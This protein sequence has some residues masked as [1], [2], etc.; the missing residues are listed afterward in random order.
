MTDEKSNS[1]IWKLW[2]N[3][4]IDNLSLGELKRL[5]RLSSIKG[6]RKENE[7]IEPVSK[8]E[9]EGERKYTSDG[10][11]KFTTWF[12]DYKDKQNEEGQGTLTFF[13]D[14]FTNADSDS[15][16]EDIVS[17]W[18][19]ADNYAKQVWSTA[20]CE[21]N[22]MSLCVKRLHIN[23]GDGLGLQIKLAGKIAAPSEKAS[24]ECNS[25]ASITFT[26]YPLTIKQ[27]GLESV[28][29]E[30]DSFDV[31]GDLMQSYI[32][33]MK[34]SYVEY[35]DGQIYNELKTATEGTTETLPT[36][37]ACDPALSGSCCSDTALLDMWNA[38]NNAIASMREGTGLKQPYNPTH[39]IISP[40]VAKVFKRMQ[41][42][43]TSFYKDVVFDSK[44]KLSSICGLKAVEYCGAQSCCTDSG[45]VVAIIVDS[46]R[47]VGCVFGK[48][49]HMYSFFQSNCNSVR[50]DM[51][52]FVAI[53]ELDC[54]GIC[55]IKNP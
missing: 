34:N 8:L 37:L 38:T 11:G 27:L 30:K 10:A 28:V 4:D 19:P 45:A 49:P 16:C 13:N 53:S 26:T 54:D 1:E 14:Y 24:C 41:T 51:W 46:S 40:S 47:A 55:H 3:D 44:G 7:I 15:G 33:A 20:V 35:F 31:G 29:C 52:S 2:M 6:S 23:A 48:R 32:T 42:P 39:I 43:T 21:S 25:C 17:D 18:S 12:N 5:E 36:A 50:L 22:L 9:M